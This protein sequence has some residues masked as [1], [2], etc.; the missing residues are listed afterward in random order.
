MSSISKTRT[1][2]SIIGVPVL[3]LESYAEAVAHVEETVCTRRKSFCIAINPEKVQ[4]AKQDKQLLG[5][6]RQ[7]DLG[8]CD[9]VG[10][11]LAAKL[12]HGKSIARC[13]GCDLFLQLLAVGASKDWRIFLL[14]ASPESNAGAHAKL[15]ELHPDLTICGRQDGYFTDSRAVVERINDSGADLLF[16]AMGSPKQEYW[17]SKHRAALDVPFCMGVGGSFDI[18]SGAATR[19]PRLFRKTGTEFLYRLAANPRRLRRQMALPG[20]LFSV[21]QQRFARS[22]GQA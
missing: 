10:I 15:R 7:A 19:A 5:V 3:P 17:I 4:R 1:P 12:L 9:G 18:L 14:G 22:K 16:V 8:I 20:F 21:L 6:L 2:L 13:T 11:V